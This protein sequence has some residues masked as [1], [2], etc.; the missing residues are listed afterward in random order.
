MIKD[1]NLIKL[2][3]NKKQHKDKTVVLLYENKNFEN[4][5]LR[6]FFKYLV[7]S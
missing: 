5:F 1:T 4:H 3:N 7:G 2:N 6:I